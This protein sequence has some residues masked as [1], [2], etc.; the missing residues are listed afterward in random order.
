MHPHF[1]RTPRRGLELQEWDVKIFEILAR[2]RSA[3]TSLLRCLADHE[4]RRRGIRSTQAR[5]KLLHDWGFVD[6]PRQ[7][8][9]L[10]MLG[11]QHDLVYALGR[12]GAEVL[13]ERTGRDFSPH[14]FLQKNR[15]MGPDSLQHRLGLARFGGCLELALRSAPPEGVADSTHPYLLRPWVPEEALKAMLRQPHSEGQQEGGLPNPDGFFGLQKPK[16]PPNRAYFFVEY[17]RT[18]PSSRRRF[19]QAKGIAYLNFWLQGK[20]EERLGIRNFRILILA[21][22]LE[23]MQTLRGYLRHW[24]Q[25][26]QHQLAGMWLFTVETNYNLDRPETVLGRIWRSVETDQEISLLD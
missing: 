15:E 21:P 6:R 25:R 22:T 11:K 7:Q 12:R 1:I 5:C 18:S 23:R 9:V 16:P 14:R 24:L 19:V 17:Q 13:A 26:E 2:Y 10:R 20:H 4:G 8:L 3:E